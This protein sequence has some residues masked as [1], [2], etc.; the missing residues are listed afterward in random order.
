VAPEPRPFISPAPSRHSWAETR[1][2]A[3]LTRGLP[4]APPI[5]G[6][7]IFSPTMT[8]KLSVLRRASPLS[9]LTILL[10][11]CGSSAEPSSN[12]GDVTQLYLPDSMTV[13]LGDTARIDF[14]ASDSAGNTAEGAVP[15]W[16]SL[17]PAIVEVS[18]SGVVS[19]RGVG[20]TRI[21]VRIGTLRDSLV[22]RVPAPAARISI[23][24]QDSVVVTEAAHVFWQVFDSLGNEVLDRTPVLELPDTVALRPR[25]SYSYPFDALGRAP[26]LGHVRLRLG[27]TV[28]IDSIRVLPRPVSIE[29]AG[30]P[31]F[32]FAGDSVQLEAVLR[33]SLGNVLAGRTFSW[34]G[35]VNEHGVITSIATGTVPAVAALYVAG[36]PL[37]VTRSLPVRMRGA[38]TD[39]AAGNNHTCFLAESGSAYCA[40][41]GAYGETGTIYAPANRPFLVAGGL[42]FSAL[43]AAWH[44]QCGLVLTG[45]AWCWGLASDG[46]IGAPVS[47]VCTGGDL[48]ALAPMAVTGGH[49]FT[50][51]AGKG[52]TFC[53]L[54]ASGQ[55]WCWGSNNLGQLG[56]G[57]VDVQPHTL[58]QAVDQG[59]AS[60][61]HLAASWAM[62]CGLDA[63]GQAWC[64][65]A[66]R[67]RYDHLEGALPL[68]SRPT[69]VADTLTFQSL[70]GGPNDI[71]GIT[72]GGAGA[73]W[74]VRTDDGLAAPVVAPLAGPLAQFALGE[75]HACALRTD[76]T[77]WCWG[78]DLEG[79]RGDGPGVTP[80]DAPPTQVTG[81]LLFSALWSGSDQSCGLALDHIAWC[82][83]DN[84]DFQLGTTTFTTFI[85][86]EV[87]GQ[88]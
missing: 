41:F 79:M 16:S 53:G 82:W 35:N 87:V 47:S 28:Q 74:G 48:C 54:T 64:W 21:K 27:R 20:T 50:A 45:E 36:I 52:A 24:L 86:A 71:C 15:S 72:V 18:P 14:W 6:V 29:I 76:G 22:V 80:E 12:P 56:T 9:L 25:D 44:S 73:C 39:A 42:R 65:G 84:G 63:A 77:A 85:P 88:R 37:S 4:L 58:P 3:E 70:W 68:W 78:T 13:E 31:P 55:A 10:V 75:Y 30:L 23:T 32:I 1:A 83:G 60:F 7:A 26:G 43:A 61:R 2:H 57:T 67:Q 40:G 46:Q 5:V 69:R 19:A 59:S 51:L 62:N 11:A 33:D 8:Q 81:G 49:Q 38:V 17:A 34:G 66:A